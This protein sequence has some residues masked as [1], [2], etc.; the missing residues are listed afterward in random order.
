MCLCVCGHG[1]VGGWVCLCVCGWV[2]L[3]VCLCLCADV[4]VGVWCGCV[5]MP[6]CVCVCLCVHS[7]II[8]VPFL[9][10]YGNSNGDNVPCL[11]YT[12][13]SRRIY[14]YCD[15][16]LETM[17]TTNALE[18]IESEVRY[19]AGMRC[20]YSVCLYYTY[21]FTS[22]Y[23]VYAIQTVEVSVPNTSI[24]YGWACLC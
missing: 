8:P 20:C 10:N 2:C 24:Q 9:G 11:V 6:V 7:I 5:C 4:A 22:E 15:V 17:T 3:C 18:Y 1:Q 19:F 14:I 12:T 23:I 21:T 16:E 13:F